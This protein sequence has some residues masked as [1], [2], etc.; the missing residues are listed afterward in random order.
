M[1]RILGTGTETHKKQHHCISQQIAQRMDCIGYHRCRTTQNAGNEFEDN[2]G[3]IDNTA[4]NGGLI[5]L[6][7]TQGIIH[8]IC[9]WHLYP[10][11]N[12]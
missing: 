1:I 9:I 12:K 4:R 10:K 6:P 3:N 11:K 7:A 5:Y 8:N 2:Q